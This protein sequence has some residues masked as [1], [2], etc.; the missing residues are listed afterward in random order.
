[1]INKNVDESVKLKESAQ[2]NRAM[3]AIS[4]CNNAKNS[5]DTAKLK[6]M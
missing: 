3:F 2:K 4:L 1:M 6:V 5:V